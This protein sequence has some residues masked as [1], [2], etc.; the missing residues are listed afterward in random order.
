[1]ALMHQSFLFRLVKDGRR[2]LFIVKQ[3][4]DHNEKKESLRRCDSMAKLFIVR[5]K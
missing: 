1:M 3:A 5:K 4:A 2:D